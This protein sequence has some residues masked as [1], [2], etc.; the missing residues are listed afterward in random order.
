MQGR[1]CQLFLVNALTCGLEVCMAAG[2]FYIP[3]LLLQA[4]M[5]ERYMTMV[6]GESTLYDHIVILE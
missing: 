4:G 2:T 6:L 5:E 1:V 3:P